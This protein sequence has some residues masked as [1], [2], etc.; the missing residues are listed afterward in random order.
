MQPH[1]PLDADGFEDPIDPETECRK[2]FADLRQ[3]FGVEMEDGVSI[4][5]HAARIMN[6]R[7]TIRA[8]LATARQ[9][10]EEDRH[11]CAA[12]EVGRGQAQDDTHKAMD[13]R[14]DERTRANRNGDRVTDFM[15]YV[16]GEVEAHE[17]RDERD[18]EL[19][20][21]DETNRSTYLWEREARLAGMRE[22]VDKLLPVV[23][24][25]EAQQAMPDD[26]F[27]PFIDDAKALGRAALANP[28]PDSARWKLEREAVDAAR[29]LDQWAGHFG[30]VAKNR[31]DYDQELSSR[32][33]ALTAALVKLDELL[34]ASPKDS[35]HAD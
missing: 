25:L 7:F 4:L 26:K 29:R 13:D 14:D 6:E 18:R 20:Q 31:E 1:P 19:C 22:A 28:S 35:T 15:R 21:R 16:E 12:A 3:I 11:N 27:Q 8:E 17:V 24:G 33:M 5:D 9:D 34:A 30:E 2:I 23:L 32:E 10:A